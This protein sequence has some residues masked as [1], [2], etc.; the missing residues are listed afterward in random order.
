M[1][2]NTTID[3]LTNNIK[4]LEDMINTHFE[5]LHKINELINK[6]K[7]SVNIIV[8]GGLNNKPEEIIDNIETWNNPNQCKYS[9]MLKFKKDLENGYN[10]SISA[11]DGVYPNNPNYSNNLEIPHYKDS[12]IL[13]SVES[14]T[15]IKYFKN[16]AINIVVAFC[17]IGFDDNWPNNNEPP[18]FDKVK[19]YDIRYIIC[20]C[21]WGNGFPTDT[22]MNILQY[23]LKTPTEPYSVESYLYMIKN[24]KLF[25]EKNI[26][27]IMK[28]YI[29]PIFQILG[30]PT[31]RGYEG[32]S[33]KGDNKMKELIA[34]LIDIPIFRNHFNEEQIKDLE[35]YVKSTTTVW[36][37]I[38]NDSK[39]NIDVKHAFC[40]L[41]YG[42]NECKYDLLNK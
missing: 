4:L 39:K 8:V 10:V 38:N 21:M 9:D 23:D 32:N 25:N 16:N 14:E 27:Q 1:E 15:G 18:E 20:G 19:N 31:F 3:N 12:F 34:N 36:N 17:P 24:I 7:K 6:P 2:S 13:N 28:P 22:I 37:K 5:K 41:V 11:F 33:Y 26:Y 42:I 40:K 35:N 30:N 29:N